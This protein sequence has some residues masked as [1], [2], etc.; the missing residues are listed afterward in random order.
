MTNEF[1]TVIDIEEVVL[2]VETGIITKKEAKDLLF[3]E[4]KEEDE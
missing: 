3:V 1:K 2:L 4:T